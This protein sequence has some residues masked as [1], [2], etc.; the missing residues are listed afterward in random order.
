MAV[1]THPR[2]QWL[3]QLCFMPAKM[4][5]T[6]G[7]FNIHLNLRLS[8]SPD[9]LCRIRL[10][11]SSNGELATIQTAPAFLWAAAWKSVLQKPALLSASLA[12]RP[13]AAQSPFTHS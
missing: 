1:G 13:Q 4:C 7:A 11:T 10:I 12:P 6:G 5:P 9:Y 8:S 2:G 3:K